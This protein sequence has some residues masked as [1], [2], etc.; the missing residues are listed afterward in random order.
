VSAVDPGTRGYGVP[1]KFRAT[2]TLNRACVCAIL[3]SLLSGHGGVCVC[4]R[5]ELIY[6]CRWRTEERDVGKFLV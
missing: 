2:A 3:G 4:I 5:V 6:V 1:L